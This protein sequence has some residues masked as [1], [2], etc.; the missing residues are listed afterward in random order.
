MKIEITNIKNTSTELSFIV[1][2]KNDDKEEHERIFFSYS[3]MTPP[4]LKAIIAVLCALIGKNKYEKVYID[5]DMERE[6]A[7]MARKFIGC[8]VSFKSISEKL[9]TY[10]T[11]I[12]YD[13]NILVNFSGGFDSLALLALLPEEKTKLVSLN[14]G[15]W[16]ERESYSFTSYKTEIV[17][18]NCRRNAMNRSID[19]AKNNWRFMGCASILMQ[20]KYRANYVSFGSVFDSSALYVANRHV[21]KTED[22]LFYN[23]GMR[24]FP[25]AKGFTQ[26]GSIMLVATFFPD[27]VVQV[28]DSCAVVGSDKRRMKE[29]FL[30]ALSESKSIG[31]PKFEETV[32]DREKKK[33]GEHYDYD[34]MSLY[35]LKK[36]G[37]D[38][39]SEIMDNIPD[40]AISLCERLDLSFF[41]RINTNYL[42]ELPSWFVGDYLEKLYKAGIVPYTQDDFLELEEVFRFLM[43]YKCDNKA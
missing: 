16:F 1:C 40:E 5:I 2:E 22:E 10:E 43:K 24:D 3:E 36:F 33:F 19:L 6:L 30:K 18:T 31:V 17:S 41:E 26:V 13:D 28:L 37:K 25:V 34:I 14:F 15:G 42:E 9:R 23:I 32:C 38:V 8:E 4:S 29:L 7:D 27:K 39:A 35:I 21:H 12:I 11:S 20:E